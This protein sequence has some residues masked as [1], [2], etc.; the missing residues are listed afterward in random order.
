VTPFE[1]LRMTP[2]ID[3]EI[4]DIRKAEFQKPVLDLIQDDEKLEVDN[5]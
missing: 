2:L 3:C 4:L 1:S 5:S